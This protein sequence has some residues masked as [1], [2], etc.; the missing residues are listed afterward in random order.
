[1]TWHYP[2][3]GKTGQR[4]RIETIEAMNAAITASELLDGWGFDYG[5]DAKKWNPATV[6]FIGDGCTTQPGDRGQL[7]EVNLF[8]A[9]EGDPVAFATKMG[10]F[11]ESQGYTVTAVGDIDRGS[12]HDTTFRADRPDGS[13]YAAVTSY[14]G[15]FNLSVYSECSTDP[16]LDKFAGPNGYRT[17]D[18]SDPNPYNPTNSPSVTPYPRD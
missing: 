2:D 11:W 12:E 10:E 14:T 13:L 1:M 6:E 16:S 4:L 18:D 5:P 15:S 8:H 3:S 7:F 9:P 17:F